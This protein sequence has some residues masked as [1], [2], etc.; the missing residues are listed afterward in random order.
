MSGNRSNTTLTRIL[1]LKWFCLVH[2]SYVFSYFVLR[3]FM[4]SFHDKFSSNKT[5]RIFIL[6][7]LLISWLFIFNTG[8]EEGMLY[9]LPDLWNNEN[10]VF[11]TFSDSL[12]AQNRSLKVQHAH[13]KI[14]D[15]WSLKCFKSILEI[16]HSNYL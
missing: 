13:W 6:L 7:T 1:Y 9:F 15:K 16:W 3:Y 5:P 11:P 2:E 12:F 10:L 4:C 14:T 8:R